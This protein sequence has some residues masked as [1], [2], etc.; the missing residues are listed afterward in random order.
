VIPPDAALSASG[1]ESHDLPAGA[2]VSVLLPLAGPPGALPPYPD[3]LRKG[4]LRVLRERSADRLAGQAI[5]SRLHD[6]PGESGHPWAVSPAFASGVLALQLP[7][8]W[9][10]A[11]AALRT[12]WRFSLFCGS[13]RH[14]TV[15]FGQTL[16]FDVGALAPRSVAASERALAG[17]TLAAGAE[18]ALLIARH[19]HPLPLR[20][21]EPGMSAR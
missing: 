1:R 8:G 17:P 3:L 12:L 11:H 21:R 15:G 13:G 5:A 9:T 10:L 2:A 20:S 18:R 16:P 4:V 19:P 7:P 6:D 14:L